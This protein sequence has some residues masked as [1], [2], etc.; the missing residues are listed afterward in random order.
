MLFSD[1]IKGKDGDG[2][3]KQV[4]SCVLKPLKE[5]LLE[6]AY[7]VPLWIGALVTCVYY[8]Y[9]CFISLS[10]IRSH[11]LALHVLALCYIC[12]AAAC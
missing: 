12:F 8:K 9:L 6:E 4:S 2:C 3:L 1:E 7:R 10:Y 11:L 5:L